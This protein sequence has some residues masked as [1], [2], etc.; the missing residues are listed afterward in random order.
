VLDEMGWLTQSSQEE[1]AFF[2]CDL[3]WDADAADPAAAVR[4]CYA[5]R[6]SRSPDPRG[7]APAALRQRQQDWKC[8]D[9]LWIV[10]VLAP[11]G[12]AGGILEDLKAKVIKDPEIKFRSV[13]AGEA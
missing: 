11:F 5:T 10:E 1:Q 8:S 9:E 7:G 4:V 13:K 6:A 3:E 2:L 12:D